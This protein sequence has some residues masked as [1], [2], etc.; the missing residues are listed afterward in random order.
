MRSSELLVTRSARRQHAEV[1]HATGRRLG[2][3]RADRREASFDWLALV[4]TAVA[5]GIAG[6]LLWCALAPSSAAA[7]LAH[8]VFRPLCH[9]LPARSFHVAG[10]VLPVCH[11]CTG[12]YVGLAAGAAAAWCGWW[13]APTS[14]AFWAVALAPMLVSP[15]LDWVWLQTASGAWFGGLGAWAVVRS[16]RRRPAS[17]TALDVKDGD[18]WTT[19][20]TTCRV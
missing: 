20:T 16:L 3:G 11:R 8:V 19:K 12:L 7:G 13:R 10:G 17:R 2:P 4:F 9:Q 15:A 6:A 1:A 18:P 5:C 14:R